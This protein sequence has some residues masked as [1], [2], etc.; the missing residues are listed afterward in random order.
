MNIVEAFSNGRWTIDGSDY[1]PDREILITNAIEIGRR[2][3]EAK[4][5]LPHGEWGK[6]LK[7]SVSERP[8]G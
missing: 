2:L 6:W 1:E 5:L 8:T 4:G 7:E 3:K